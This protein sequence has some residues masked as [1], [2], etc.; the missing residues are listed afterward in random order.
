MSRANPKTI[1]LARRI[2]DI[3]R[4]EGLEAGT[5]LP[6]TGL[7][8]RL[9]VSRSPV[10]TALALLQERGVVST[11]PNQGYF[12]LCN[13]DS[14]AFRNAVPPESL[15]ER[16]TRD[17]VRARF[18]NLV[19][20]QVSVT[21]VMRRYDLDRPSANRILS[22][23]ARD[24]IVERA[25][26]QGYSF[27]PVLND[28]DAYEESYR[29]RLLIEPAAILEPDFAPDPRRFEQ[30]RK[31]HVDLLDAGVDSAPMSELF[32]IDAEFHEAIAEAC[33]NR[34]LRHAIQLQT[35]LRRLSEYENY[36]ERSRLR[37]SCEEHLAI[38]DAIKAGRVK[39]AATLMRRHIEVSRDV[40]P[41]FNKVRALAH[42]K[43]T[44]R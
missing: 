10:R 25:A 27:G 21:D 16:I 15:D 11:A 9:G 23:M 12:L 38:M 22:G 36:S 24:G 17:L 13:T 5:H 31:R 14:E 37:D 29:Y 44:R 26:G 42:R 19:P 7:A 20:E 30:L 35:R 41:N 6:E 43:M 40:R 32:E 18:A 3:V 1:A 2:M 8:D 4:H 39:E 34:F 28:A 33:G